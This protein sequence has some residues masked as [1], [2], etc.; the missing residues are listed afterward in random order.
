MT[1]EDKAEI[2]EHIKTSIIPTSESKMKKFIKAESRLFE[3][4]TSKKTKEILNMEPIID[5]K[6]LEVKELLKE[7][8]TKLM[9]LSDIETRLVNLEQSKSDIDEEAILD[10]LSRH[11]D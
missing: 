8:N 4:K 7:V 11:M 2:Y 9:V 5:A 1:P 6:I 10:I 3:I